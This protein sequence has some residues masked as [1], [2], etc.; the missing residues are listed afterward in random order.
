MESIKEMSWFDYQGLQK[1][2]SESNT[3]SKKGIIPLKESQK[4][5]IKELKE[6]ETHGSKRIS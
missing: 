4:D 1:F 5:M 6:R 2:L 3:K